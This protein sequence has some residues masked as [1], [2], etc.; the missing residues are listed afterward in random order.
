MNIL[1]LTNKL[2]STKDFGQILK[3]ELTK[4]QVRV[5]I[6]DFQFALSNIPT[7]ELK[8]M[9]FVFLV[10]YNLGQ[11]KGH[12]DLRYDN[13]NRETNVEILSRNIA[14]TV[15]DTLRSD[16]EFQQN[17]KILKAG[18]STDLYDENTLLIK[19]FAKNKNEEQNKI[20]MNLFASIIT[21][22]LV[23]I[24]I[25]KR[26]IKKVYT[27]NGAVNNIPEPI[28]QKYLDKF[29]YEKVEE[30]IEEKENITSFKKD[31]VTVYDGE[32]EN[33]HQEMEYKPNVFNNDNYSS[34]DENVE[35]IECN[36]IIN[37][38]FEYKQDFPVNASED[39]LIK[40]DLQGWIIIQNSKT[41]EIILNKVIPE[42]SS[43]KEDLL[44]AIDKDKYSSSKIIAIINNVPQK[45]VYNNLTKAMNAV[46]KGYKN[47]EIMLQSID[48]LGIVFYKN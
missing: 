30:N 15:F 10:S 7:F 18:S 3:K 35:K 48:D 9:D 23:S 21:N 32:L 24:P 8:K 26:R 45:V 33:V 11:A 39:Q 46:S 22:S 2:Q 1:I 34:D 16:N 25:I 4:Y 13:K 6:C 47:K 44:Q 37:G 42:N 20:K 12:I 43:S 29:E 14:T 41:R 36:V 19:I 17:V 40:N 5:E 28:I 31:N 38:K 27:Y